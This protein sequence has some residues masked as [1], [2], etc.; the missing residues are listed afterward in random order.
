MCIAQPDNLCSSSSTSLLRAVASLL[1]V[2]SQSRRET[3]V[4]TSVYIKALA[5]PRFCINFFFTI[6]RSTFALCVS[7]SLSRLRWCALTAARSIFTF[8]FN[9]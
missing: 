5:V 9:S 3:H 1:A 4:I 7:M 2:I 8:S 6:L